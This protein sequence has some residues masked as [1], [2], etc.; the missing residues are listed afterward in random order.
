MKKKIYLSVY[1]VLCILV[2][3]C[4]GYEPIYSSSNIQFKIGNHIIE[5]EKIL[6]NKIYKNIYRI[7]SSN[8]AD[9]NSKIIDIFIKVTKTK[10]STLKD[11]SG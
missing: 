5:G 9:E 6:G 4:V 8:K 3:G 11:S 1:I 2:S 7:T 10:S